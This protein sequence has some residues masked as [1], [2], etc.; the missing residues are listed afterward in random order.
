MFIDGSTSVNIIDTVLTSSSWDILVVLNQT[1]LLQC[2]AK[3]IHQGQLIESVKI[4]WY[5]L[6]VFHCK[7]GKMQECS[8]LIV[9]RW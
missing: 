8:V 5:F 7:A 4:Q 6:N 1:L 9:V 3:L 2:T